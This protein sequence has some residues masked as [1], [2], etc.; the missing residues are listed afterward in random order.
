MTELEAPSLW[1]PDRCSR[2][3]QNERDEKKKRDFMST[4]TLLARWQANWPPIETR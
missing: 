1:G 2:W 4:T 3:Q